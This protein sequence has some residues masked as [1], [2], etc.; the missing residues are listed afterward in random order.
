MS[1][2]L[3]WREKLQ[4]IYAQYSIYIRKALQFVL[5]LVLFGLINSNVGFMEAASSVF[6]TVGLAA[7]CTFLPMIVTVFAATVLV[8][9]HFYALSMPVAAV[10]FVVFL[11][12]YI[13]YFRFTP[14]K[15]WLVLLPAIAFGL[16][17]PFVIPVVFGLMGTPTWI[18]P[19]AC[20]VVSFYMTETVKS[21][22]AAFR[23]TDADGLVTSLMSFTRQMLTNQEMWLMVMAVV[24]G[25]LV[26]NLVRTRAIDH[27]WKIASASGAAVS[28]VVALAGNIV[29]DGGISYPSAVLSAVLGVAVGLVLEFLFFSVDYSRTENIQFEDD[30]Y[31]YYVK[32]VPKV[33]V[34]VPEKQVKRITGSQA[35]VSGDSAEND[36]ETPGKKKAEKKPPVSRKNRSTEEPAKQNTEEI[37]LT[38]SL[39]RELGL[40]Q[41]KEQPR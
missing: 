22:A 31:Y 11:L 17:I 29:L 3:V 1:T 5:G 24:L 7:V 14:G 30:E 8:L 27:A 6:C 26:V 32:A 15:A 10:S 34:S 41:D 39:S 35:R 40:D 20:G 28:L 19:A 23:S 4:N 33:G 37:L 2:L 12:M 21:S 38:R 25:V 9:V 16:K 13:F 36:A 18:V